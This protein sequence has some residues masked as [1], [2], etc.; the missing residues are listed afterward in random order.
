MVDGAFDGL[1]HRPHPGKI[2]RAFVTG[3]SRLSFG[4]TAAATES[5]ELRLA[6]PTAFVE[7]LEEL[8]DWLRHGVIREQL[9]VSAKRDSAALP[10]LCL[11][12][13]KGGIHRGCIVVLQTVAPPHGFLFVRAFQRRG[14]TS[15]SQ[16]SVKESLSNRVRRKGVNEGFQERLRVW[17]RYIWRRGKGFKIAAKIGVLSMLS[18]LIEGLQL[19]APGESFYLGLGKLN[20][21]QFSFLSDWERFSKSFSG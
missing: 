18:L 14:W 2:G 19:D 10:I 11:D 3:H 1:E 5:L 17:P 4:G 16:E 12:F 6:T 13:F 7:E 15:G 8:S 20:F 21:L 9:E